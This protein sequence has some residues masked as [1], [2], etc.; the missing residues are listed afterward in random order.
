MMEGPVSGKQ[1][2]VNSASHTKCL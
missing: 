2:I 1:I